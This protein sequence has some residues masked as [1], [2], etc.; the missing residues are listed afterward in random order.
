MCTAFTK[1]IVRLLTRPSSCWHRHTQIT[2]SDGR[3][4]NLNYGCDGFQ[5][6]M[7]KKSLWPLLLL[8]I[9][10]NIPLL[11]LEELVLSASCLVA[12]DIFFSF[13][14]S[15]FFLGGGGG[16]GGDWERTLT[17]TR[18]LYFTRIVV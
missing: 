13:F 12:A 16:I 10:L 5:R 8:F 9:P 14:F 6:K 15:L 3:I 18:K 7:E 4:N 2:C 11:R 1:I 17:Q